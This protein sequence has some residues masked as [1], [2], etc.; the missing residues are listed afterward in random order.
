[1]N[2]ISFEDRKRTLEEIKSLFFYTLY[3]WTKS[4]AFNNISITCQNKLLYILKF[5]TL[6]YNQISA[7]QRLCTLFLNQIKIK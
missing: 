6:K 5:H 4:Y 2:D 1:M 3:L 7:F